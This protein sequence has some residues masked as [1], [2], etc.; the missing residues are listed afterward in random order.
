M[1]EKPFESTQTRSLNFNDVQYI[2]QFSKCIHQSEHEMLLF[3]NLQISKVG[4]FV[5]ND[6]VKVVFFITDNEIQAEDGKHN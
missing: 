1:N 6:H 2:M 4:Y 5:T 3:K